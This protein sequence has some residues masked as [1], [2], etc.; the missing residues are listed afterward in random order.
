MA[1]NATLT[2]G[3]DLSDFDKA[4]KAINRQSNDLASQL[5]KAIKTPIEAYKE[6]LKKL[7][8]NPLDLDTK[9]KLS[10][11]GADIKKMATTKLNLDIQNAR[12][13]IENL[14]T[15]IVATLG[16]ALV[17]SKPIS[18]SIEFESSMADVKK[19]VDF[20]NA[21]EIKAFSNDIMKMSR[22]IPLSV[23]ELAQITASGGQLGIAKENLL[24][25]TKTAAMMGV[26]FDMSAKDA[27][28]NMAT[29][30]NIFNMNVDEVG[31]LGDTINHISN[32]SASTAQKIVAAV[33]RIAGNAKDFGL[34]ADA[35]AGLASSFI[36]LGKAPEVA[37]TA[38]NSMLTV[39]NN[40]DNA[41]KEVSEAFN[42]IGIDGKELKRAILKDPQ[43]AL[44]QFLHTLSKIPKAQKTGIL[45]S[46]FGKN[47][48]DDISLVT[49][50]I[51]NFDKAMTLSG[52]SKKAGSMQQEFEARSATTAN[53]IQLMKSAF[54][55]IAIN[56]GNVF[57]PT[58][59]VAIN[60]IRNI[61]IGIANFANTFPNLVKVVFGGMLAITAF[62]AAVLAKKLAVQGAIVVGGE[63]RNFLMKLPFDCL[64]AGGALN[65]CSLNLQ[66]FSFAM[67]AAKL[68]AV[69]TFAAIKTAAI[70][71]IR[72]IGTALFTNPIGLLL[73]GIAVVATLIYKYWEPLSAFF[74]GFFEGVGMAFKPFIQ[75]F[76]N[77][78]EH[79]KNIFAPVIELFNKIFSP[80]EAS[81]GELGNLK[82]M[83]VDF[84]T[85]F[86][87]VLR[88]LLFP[89]EAVANIIEAIG[90]I[91]DIVKL[92]GSAWIDAFSQELEWWKGLFSDIGDFFVEK[93]DMVTQG[94][95]NFFSGI[96]D[97]IKE[98][99]DWLMDKVTAVTDVFASVKDGAKDMLGIG[100]G[101]EVNW[102]NPLSWFN[103]DAPIQTTAGAVD[104]VMQDKQTAQINNKKA[105]TLND[106]KTISINMY[107]T[108]AT[109][110]NVAAA[111]SENG[112]SFTD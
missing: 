84:G 101:K 51:E 111:V 98:K 32:N 24:D 12:K 71:S 96:F 88:T 29:L 89:I 2:F 34:T 55:E 66:N 36:A 56:I 103:D 10:K 50:A 100:D 14:K 79:I 81:A 48:G 64:K 85:V 37:S 92:K 90:L 8:I 54:N 86:G 43:K 104:Q 67:V 102:Y 47:F 105:Q 3:M 61:S 70:S 68:R 30:M 91:I 59:N 13:N 26:A 45:T 18:A 42:Q 33:G 40:A 82:N 106:N 72:A 19:V 23:N 97:W 4:M 27:G 28:D 108:Q 17:L 63:F 112:Y 107:G 1:K 62:K 35:T 53:N 87:V 25:F 9:D 21:D 7:K 76:Q 109:P 6:G 95:K 73:T 65:M 58:L 94:I 38:I 77:A 5:G 78:W 22:T 75:S 16:S 93:F 49:G 99:I 52:D 69:L 57:L 74:S 46:I 44:S 110:Q 80:I 39:L 83:G 60:V 31:K 41:S 11:L 15:D 20:K